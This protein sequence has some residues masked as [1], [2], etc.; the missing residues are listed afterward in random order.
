MPCFGPAQAPRAWSMRA[1]AASRSAGTPRS[2]STT[3]LPDGERVLPMAEP[4][5]SMEGRPPILR[6]PKLRV[7]MDALP[8]EVRALGSPMLTLSELRWLGP[9]HSDGWSFRYQMRL[10][11]SYHQFTP[12]QARFL[13]C[14]HRIVRRSSRTAVHINCSAAQVV[15]SLLAGGPCSVT[16]PRSTPQR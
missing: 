8:S 3:V 16:T 15:Q 11:Q 12:V 2:R 1:S 14:K 13:S 6:L 7:P 4:K 9:G 5:A 10:G